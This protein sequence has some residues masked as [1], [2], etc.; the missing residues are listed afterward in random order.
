MPDETLQKI[1]DRLRVLSEEHTAELLGRH[2][3]T[4]RRWRRAGIGP[5]HIKLGAK[6]VGYRVGDI[7]GFQNARRAG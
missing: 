1:E 4:L 2:V 3:Q 7:E 5:A 6:G